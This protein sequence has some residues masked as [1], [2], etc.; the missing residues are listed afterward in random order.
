VVFNY[1]NTVIFCVYYIKPISPKERSEN[2]H[3]IKSHPVSVAQKLQRRLIKI[4]V[5][6]EVDRTLKREVVTYF[7]KYSYTSVQKLSKIAGSLIQVTQLWSQPRFETGRP[8]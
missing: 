2:R 7:E 1:Q 8:Y 3:I 5:I 4:L 6:N